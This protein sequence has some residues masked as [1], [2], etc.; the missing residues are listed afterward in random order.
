[1]R[2]DLEQIEYTDAFDLIKSMLLITKLLSDQMNQLMM[3]LVFPCQDGRRMVRT[4]I[5][6]HDYDY[7]LF[8][9]SL[10]YII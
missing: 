4:N 2:T 8:K 10:Y 5:I 6:S 1:M 9:S 7:Y 3:S